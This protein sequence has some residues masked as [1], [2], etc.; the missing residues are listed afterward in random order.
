MERQAC[1]ELCG[2]LVVKN[3]F[4]EVCEQSA[5]H[6]HEGLRRVAS[7]SELFTTSKE[8][9]VC[10]RHATCVG[11]CT[12]LVEFELI[13]F[14]NSHTDSEGECKSQLSC[15]SR[16]G[17][18]EEEEE[19]LSSSA[20]SAIGDGGCDSGS[21]A[22]GPQIADVERL[23]SEN[24]CL[25]HENKLLRERCL[26]QAAD[27]PVPVAASA[28]A[29][30]TA[31]AFDAVGSGGAA[32]GAVFRTS[33]RDALRRGGAHRLGLVKE[34]PP[35]QQPSQQPCALPAAA[36]E[37]HE[38]QQEQ[39]GPAALGVEG[40]PAL[41]RRQRARLARTSM[42]PISG[43]TVQGNPGSTPPCCTL[44]TDALVKIEASTSVML[45][46]LPNNYSRA[47]F[48]GMLDKEGFAGHYDFVYLPI[49]FTSH[50][51]LG[52]AVINLVDPALIPGFWNTFDGYSK[53]MI[54]SRKV[55]HVSWS[56]P[57]QGYQAH[58]EHYRNSPVMHESV[59]EAFKPIVFSGG[60]RIA[61]PAPTKT[62]KAPRSRH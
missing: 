41:S 45:W 10:A 46:N 42:L 50:A 12:E 33:L 26:L 29:A 21:G 2:R 14:R 37:K 16:G 15:Y 32:R 31:Y 17:E 3:T 61:F 1:T 36:G 27:I 20:H 19:L 7:D 56:S 5:G 60:K 57:H 43:G 52:Y 30:A 35:Q 6:Q 28:D 25:A 38:A 53:W 11:K 4:V 13:D 51:C 24:A 62:P 58:V 8:V 49:D 47:I 34:L 48:L 22:S 39:G 18:E 9:Q 40:P 44:D 54:P 55:C 59:P 23:I